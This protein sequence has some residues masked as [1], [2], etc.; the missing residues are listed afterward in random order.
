MS[1]VL[2]I[3]NLI[4]AQ[5]KAWEEFKSA[6]DARLDQIEQKG[7]AAEDVVAKVATINA[8]LDKLSKDIADQMLKLQRPNMGDSKGLTSEQVEHKQALHGYLTKGDTNGLKDIERKA[9]SSLI[10]TSAGYLVT[11]EM[12]AQI[13]RVMPTL[14]AMFRI[15]R[16][17]NVGTQKW[18]KRT[19]TSGMTMARPGQG[20]TSG[21]TTPPNWAK[22][23]IEA[24]NAEVEPWVE[25]ETLEDAD[26]DLAM[27][28]ADEAAIAFAEGLGAEYISGNGVGKARG[29]TAYD[30]VA[31]ASYAWGKVGYIASGK[32]GAFASVA[33][34]DKII[35]LQHALKAQYRNGAVFLMSDA[36]L[37]S[38]RQMKDSSG[39]YY[40]W[41]P[42]TTAG[43]GGRLL[44]SPVEVDDNMPV[45]AANSL[46]MAYGN[47]QRGYAIVNRRGTVLIRDNLTQKG[48]TKFNFTRRAGGGIYNFEAIK[49]MKFA[50]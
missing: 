36:T 9:I 11:E 39:A 20:G 4:D 21:E 27:D 46:S 41:Q 25:N 29:I 15:A 38:V 48:V 12:D 47:F 19:K 5:G 6:N 28:L 33:P 10:D 35:D 2:E 13:D 18:S 30:M 26:I 45:V 50:A 37:A 16:T 49:L 3:K 42:D 23:E 7:H 24:H 44:G 22:V 31:N 17:V 43:F 1:D 8:D 34:A 32:S 14:S 40:L